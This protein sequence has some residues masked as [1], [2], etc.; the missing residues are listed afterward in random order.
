ML[1]TSAADEPSATA[2]DVAQWPY[3]IFGL[4]AR[5]RILHPPLHLAIARAPAHPL[6]TEDFAQGVWRQPQEQALLLPYVQLNSRSVVG[7]LT[8]D[9]DHS[10]SR[11]AIK[12][13]GLPAPNYGVLNPQNGRGHWSW[14]FRAPV[15]IQ[16]GASAKTL[17]ALAAAERGIVEVTKSDASFGG[18]LTKSPLSDK[19]A[20]EL[21]SP[22]L[23]ELGD[24]I[25]ALPT[26]SMRW[27]PRPVNAH[28]YSR[29]CWVFDE[30][31]RLAYG[32]HGVRW[33][34]TAGAS[35]DAFTTHLFGIAQHLNAEFPQPLSM[36]ELRSLSK[37]IAKWT[38]LHFN[39]EKLSAI[40][41]RRGA[42]GA[43]KRWSGHM[44]NEIIKP[45]LSEGISRRTW[46]RRRGKP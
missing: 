46:Y 37:S 7:I 16:A 8:V 19:W 42:R 20:L 6:C 11:L 23:Y 21:C 12:D 5:T 31:R 30:L 40:Q 44:A 45:W 4:H 34:K 28:G 39:P 36:S 3:Q 2:D 41:S 13:S 15:P 9:N 29:N 24:L 43:A 1:I 32:K 38:W 14:V 10:Y 22:H 25:A 33:F 26:A 35:V 27:K 17:H 18:N